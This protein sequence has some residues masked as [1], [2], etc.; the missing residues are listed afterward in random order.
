MEPQIKTRPLRPKI[1]RINLS[2]AAS[3]VI[4]PNMMYNPMLNM[5]TNFASKIMDKM[6]KKGK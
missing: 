4:F 5:Q 2:L 3:R 6:F 1:E